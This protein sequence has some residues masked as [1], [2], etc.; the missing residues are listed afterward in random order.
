M[1]IAICLVAYNRVN[2]LRRLL[3]SLDSAVYPCSVKLYISID[4]S[5]ED[6]VERFAGEYNWRH[7]EKEV[8]LHGKNLGLRRH[9]LGCGD[10]LQ[11]HDALVVL[12]DDIVVAPGFFLYAQAAVEEYA[13]RTDIAGISLYSFSVNYHSCQPFTPVKESSDVYL[14]QNA[15][16][17][18]QVWMKEGWNDFKAWYDENS[19]EF[20]WMPHLPKSICSWEGSWLKYHTRFCI[21]TGRY[22]IYPYTSFS[23]CFSDVGE[24]TGI[25]SPLFQTPLL[26]AKDIKPRFCSTVKY[27]CY[28][29]NEGIFEWLGMSRDELCVDYYGDNGNGMKCRYWLSRQQLPYRVVRSFGLQLRPYELN[30]KYSVPGDDLFL[31]DTDAA[32]EVSFSQECQSRQFFYQ[33]GMLYGDTK[34]LEAEVEGLKNLAFDKEQ[35]I[36][37]QAQIISVKLREVKHWRN[38]A[39]A[40]A[41]VLVIAI[42]LYC[43]HTFA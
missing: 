18:G 41:V 28:F 24:H 37:S 25:S 36:M 42:I 12:E 26:Q 39:I 33:H 38:R 23:T 31:Y 1:D 29:E 15:Q 27:D 5:D 6:A 40:L 19:S 35:V 9:I 20:G 16:S 30:V 2:S 11:K 13:G 14:M 10:L 32:A 34:S 21:E 7:G 22:F 3:S 17:W 8:I 43:F 4:K